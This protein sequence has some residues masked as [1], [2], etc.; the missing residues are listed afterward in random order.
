MTP[1]I[2]SVNESLPTSPGEA[3]Q[4]KWTVEDKLKEDGQSLVRLVRSSEDDRFAVLKTLKEFSNTDRRYR[5]TKEIL[6]LQ[7]LHGNKGIPSV[8]AHNAAEV[9][10]KNV[11]L[12]IVMERVEGVPLANRFNEP[13][14]L[15][16]SLTLTIKICELVRLCHQSNIVHR[17]IKPDNIIINPNS[18]DI[19][20]ID[21]G[22]AWTNDVVGSFET[23]TDKELGNRFFRL[24]EMMS[25]S[26]TKDDP[27]SDL[28]FVCGIFFWLLTHRKPIQLLNEQ[29]KAPHYAMADRFPA[30]VSS[31]KRWPFIQSIFDVGFAPALRQRFQT[32][33]DLLERLNE[34]RNPV[35]P[36]STDIQRAKQE[37]DNLRNFYGRAEVA[38]QDAID[39]AMVEA[40]DALLHELHTR[41]QTNHLWYNSTGPGQAVENHTRYFRY[42]TKFRSS[43]VLWVD[44]THW[45]RLV[46]PNR[47]TSGDRPYV[48]ACFDYVSF[49]TVEHIPEPYYTGPASDTRR[50][51]S[52]VRQKAD[53]IFANL[54]ARL[55]QK[56]EDQHSN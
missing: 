25:G 9:E 23:D 15:D 40:S 17:D 33:D 48:E 14:G 24:P 38:F 13:L 20:L 29:M 36:D 18:G 7:R 12:F 45:V 41:A 26:Q 53:H 31:D 49:A 52:E 43:D 2:E 46:G 5:L 4:D 47:S 51:L 1:P 21:F 37:L 19:S 54:L 56:H 3:W 6:A 30:T 22:E 28:T 8:L 10:S 44:V 55:R 42:I 32:A 27:R 35:F 39:K 34:A 50:L 11:P 16:E